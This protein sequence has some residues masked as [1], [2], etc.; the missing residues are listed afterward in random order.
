MIP[1]EKLGA[2]CFLENLQLYVNQQTDPEKFN[3]YNGLR[4]MSETIEHLNGRVQEL[5]TLLSSINRKIDNL[6]QR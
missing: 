5:E 1:T 3:L 6:P 2:A 4:G